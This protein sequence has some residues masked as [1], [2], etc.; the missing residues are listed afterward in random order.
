MKLAQAR[1]PA[2]SKP[3]LIST[4][5]LRPLLLLLTAALL[6]QSWFLLHIVYWRSYS[7][8]TSAFM[9]DRLKIMR[10]QNPAAELTAPMGRL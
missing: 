3:R 10:Q 4:W 2:T 8:T 6:Y 9:Q 7:P 1:R 5:L